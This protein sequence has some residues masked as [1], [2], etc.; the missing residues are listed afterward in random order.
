M[1]IL[2]K[3][4]K[5][6]PVVIL[7]KSIFYNIFILC[8]W[9]RIIR[10]F[11]Q[12]V[13]FMNFPSQIFLN[14][15]NHGYRVARFKKNLSRLLPFYMT[16]ATFCFEKVRRTMR[17][18]IALYLLKACLVKLCWSVLRLLVHLGSQNTNYHRFFLCGNNKR[19]SSYMK[20]PTE[21]LY[22]AL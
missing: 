12:G 13:Q 6:P 5:Q 9:L 16:V 17:N 20:K 7:Q 21:R 11:D 18:A 22:G 15:I 2:T 10:R 8:L 1:Q 14:D 4:R 3:E 19:V